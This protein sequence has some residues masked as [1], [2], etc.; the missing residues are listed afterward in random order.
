[1]R[2]TFAKTILEAARKD[3][4]V[5]LLTGDLGFSV[6]E[7][8]MQE[9]PDQYMNCG[10]TE[11]SM[12]GVAAGLATEGMIPIIY[13]II[14]FVTMRN[15]E[16]IRND[17]CYQNLHVLVVGVGAGF[18]YGPYG[19]THHALEDI[20]FMRSLENMTV[21]APGDPHEVKML[22]EQ[23][24]HSQGPVYMRLGKAGEPILHPLGTNVEMGKSI[25]MRDGKDITIIGTSTLLSR[26][27]EVAEE[28]AKEGISIRLLSMHTIKP[29]DRQSLEKSLKT[30][31]IVTLEE[32]SVI[33][34]LGSAVSEYLA[35]RSAHPPLLSLGVPDRFTKGI[36]FQEYM[37]SLN[38]LDKESVVKT[39][40]EEYARIQKNMH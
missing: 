11:Q 23:A 22:T 38:G 24:I 15:L 14:P 17:I 4:R 18:S 37:R 27:K 20:S 33:G 29:L 36:G 12:T 19:H 13:S 39:T 31:L 32:H 7:P 3:N 9:L 34:G 1:M 10:I 30:K 28:L 6:F 35:H 8:M 40:L 16:Q 2:T 5:I 21:L 26:A 25:L